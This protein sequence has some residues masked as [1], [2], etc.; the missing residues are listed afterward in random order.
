MITII[1]GAA[2]VYVGQPLDTMKVK[3]QT[4]PK[5]YK[6][7]LDCFLQTYKQDGIYRGLYAG[8]LPSLAIGISENSI[9]FLFYGI[10]QK[11]IAYLVGYENVSEMKP[12][13]NAF[14]GAGS[15]IVSS[16]SLCPMGLVKCR[17]QSMREMA[18][19]RSIEGGRE[20]LN[21]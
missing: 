18:T 3:M 1:G 20:G 4:F 2:S 6:N 5:L 10:C 13:H 19:I 15:A 11:G 8:T 9:L 21:M 16:V 17:L 7:A 12:I 14:A